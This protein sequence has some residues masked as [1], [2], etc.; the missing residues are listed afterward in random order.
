MDPQVRRQAGLVRAEL[1]LLT[2]QVAGAESSF[3]ALWRQFPGDSA[4]EDAAL[5]GARLG[6]H[7]PGGAARSRE[8]LEQLARRAIDP[9]PPRR[10]RTPR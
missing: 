10:R 7:L 6:A 8:V 9:G 5:R 1:L 2:G 3:V 4:T